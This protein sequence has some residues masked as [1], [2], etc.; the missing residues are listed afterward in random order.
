MSDFNFNLS[1]FL[2]TTSTVFSS[3]NNWVTTLKN[4]LHS[5]ITT[6]ETDTLSSSGNVGQ[7]IY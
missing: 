6:L 1:A 7:W 2:N 5:D 3:G 4:N